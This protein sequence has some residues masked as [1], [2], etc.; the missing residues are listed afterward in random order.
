MGLSC[1]QRAIANPWRDRG[2]DS[3]LDRVRIDVDGDDHA[4]CRRAKPD[5]TESFLDDEQVAALDLQQVAFRT[6]VQ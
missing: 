5:D 4:P 6:S 3:L 2:A 1:P